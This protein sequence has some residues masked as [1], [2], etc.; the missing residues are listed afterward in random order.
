MLVTTEYYNSGG[1]ENGENAAELTKALYRAEQ[2]IDAIT[3]GKC[4]AYQELSERMLYDL[5]HAI[6]SQAEF[7]LTCGYNRFDITKAEIGDFSYQQDSDGT[8]KYICPVTMAVL[9]L[10]GLY[11]SEVS[12][13]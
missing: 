10:G 13:V 5:K 6:C 4:T 1:F 11:S 12:A 3:D 2:L 7:N 9:K 8:Y